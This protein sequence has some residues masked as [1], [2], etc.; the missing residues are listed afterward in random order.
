MKYVKQKIAALVLGAPI[1][2]LAACYG[3]EPINY[4]CTKSGG[5]KCDQYPNGKCVMED[6]KDDAGEKGGFCEYPGYKL[7]SPGRF[8]SKYVPEGQE[9]HSLPDSNSDGASDAK[10]DA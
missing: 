5:Y 9:C 3:P 2:F 1:A 10:S 8:D 6:G 4:N 7:C